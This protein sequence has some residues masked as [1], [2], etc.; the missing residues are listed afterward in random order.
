MIKLIY[1]E[2]GVRGFFKGL[3]PS[4][5]LTVNPIISFIIYEWLKVRLVD[6]K[7]N[8]SG[9]NV[10][11]MSSISKLVATLVTYPILT[12]KTLFQA[13][14]KLSSDELLIK[15]NNLL[16]KEG[17]SGLYKGRLIVI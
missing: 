5:V 3:L 10:I 17:V 11:I 4:L 13:N 14:E 8:I 7:G 9:F 6:A 12:I 2:E 15:I 1:N 16:D